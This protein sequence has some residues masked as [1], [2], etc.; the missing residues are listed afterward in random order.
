M[1]DFMGESGKSG[2][3]YLLNRLYPLKCVG[4]QRQRRELG[5]LRIPL[6][7]A[8]APN[9][10]MSEW[11]LYEGLQL[12]LGFNVTIRSSMVSQRRR[13]DQEHVDGEYY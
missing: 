6:K 1:L 5:D 10:L 13:I 12:I 11:N 9:E 2:Q 8:R 4:P 7:K 3:G